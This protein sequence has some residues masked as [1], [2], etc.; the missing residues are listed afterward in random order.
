M[1]GWPREESH[2]PTLAEVLGLLMA[3]RACPVKIQDKIAVA[4][5]GR[6]GWLSI[7]CPHPRD[8]CLL[9]RIEDSAQHDPDRAGRVLER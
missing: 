4:Q 1:T 5:I 8:C 6:I 9:N 7:L 2:R 3:P